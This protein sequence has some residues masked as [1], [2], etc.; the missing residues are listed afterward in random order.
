MTLCSLYEKIH[1]PTILGGDS[2][3]FKENLHKLHQT[4]KYFLCA[5]KK[6]KRGQCLHPGP[7]AGKGEPPPKDGI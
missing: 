5:G 2:R 6:N 3:G 4:N 7:A 1:L